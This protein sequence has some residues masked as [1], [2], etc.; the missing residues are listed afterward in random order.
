[1]VLRPIE[2]RRESHSLVE[3]RGPNN[4]ACAVYHPSPSLIPPTDVFNTSTQRGVVSKPSLVYYI[5]ALT[6]LWEQKIIPIY[7]THSSQPSHSPS[8]TEIRRRPYHD[9]PTQGCTSQAVTNALSRGSPTDM[10]SSLGYCCSYDAILLLPYS[11]YEF[12]SCGTK[13]CP[14]VIILARTNILQVRLGLTSRT[15]TMDSGTGSRI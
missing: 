6:Y 12:T 9:L 3:G 10:E 15:C 2:K 14:K 1:M 11:L 4:G 5:P 7:G 8:Q 13:E